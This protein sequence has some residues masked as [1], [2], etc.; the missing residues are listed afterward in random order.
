MGLLLLSVL[1]KCFAD[2]WEY[3]N[4][5]TITYMARNKQVVNKPKTYYYKTI[6]FGRS[7]QKWAQILHAF[8]DLS[9]L[10]ECY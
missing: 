7:N 4:F 10:V 9:R 1:N 8:P 2:I 6:L 5:A 3:G